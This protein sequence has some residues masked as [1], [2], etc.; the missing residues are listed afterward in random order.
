MNGSNKAIDVAEAF[1]SH[2]SSVYSNSDDTTEEDFILCHMC[3]CES[4]AL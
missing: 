3:N 2:F 4:C 1:A